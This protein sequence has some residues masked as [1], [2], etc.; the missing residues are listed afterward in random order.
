M[1]T[2][3]SVAY[4]RSLD[5]VLSASE[6]ENQDILVENIFNEINGK[7][8]QLCLHSETSKVI[9][10]VLDKSTYFQQCVFFDRLSGR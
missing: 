5:S 9:E 10:K 8:I 1:L 4:F 7:E 6:I 3:E 2:S